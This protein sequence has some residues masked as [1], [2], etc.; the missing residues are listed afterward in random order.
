MNRE[1]VI[2]ILDNIG[3]EIKKITNV[4]RKFDYLKRI[5]LD[6]N[7]VLIKVYDGMTTHFLRYSQYP[8][9]LENVKSHNKNIRELLDELTYQYLYY[10][11][12]LED[13]DGIKENV[14]EDENPVD[15]NIQRGGAVEEKKRNVLLIVD[16]LNKLRAELNVDKYDVVDNVLVYKT[17]SEDKVDGS[18]K[19]VKKPE[20]KPVANNVIDQLNINFNE[21][22]FYKYISNINEYLQQITLV[23]TMTSNTLNSVKSA[24]K[25]YLQIYNTQYKSKTLKEK[26]EFLYRSLTSAFNF[27]TTVNRITPNYE[28]KTVLNYLKTART[29]LLIFKMKKTFRRTSRSL[30]TVRYD[31]NITNV[32]DFTNKFLSELFEDNTYTRPGTTSKLFIQKYVKEGVIKLPIQYRGSIS[33][34]KDDDNSSDTKQLLF[35]MGN[36]FT[37]AEREEAYKFSKEMVKSRRINKTMNVPKRANPYIIV[38]KVRLFLDKDANKNT[39]RNVIGCD[40]HKY[41]LNKYIQQGMTPEELQKKQLEKRQ[42]MKRQEFEKK[43][44]ELR[45]KLLNPNK[46]VK[47]EQISRKGNTTRKSVLKG[48]RRTRK[49]RR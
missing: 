17:A 48:G 12:I 34:F 8:K 40:Y 42:V 16:D 15:E 1:K 43:K 30:F 24:M 44:E 7:Y 35:G 9:F 19:V 22:D 45:R 41:M 18:N 49:N 14:D 39:A 4:S 11:K 38:I 2:E 25:N 3:K 20:S 21:V 37:K 10:N 13:I 26:V 28:V 31:E 23:N 6:E 36:V 5:S 46:R 29:Y 47:S 33:G 27:L 32:N